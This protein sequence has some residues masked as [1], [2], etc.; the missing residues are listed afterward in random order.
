[1]PKE[2]A[3][4]KKTKSTRTPSAYNKYMK[5]EIAKVKK[6]NPE[7]THKEAFK[8][9]ANNWKTAKENPKAA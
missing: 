3:A 9:A 5:D 6:A 2:A 1:M 7:L 4:E 8:V